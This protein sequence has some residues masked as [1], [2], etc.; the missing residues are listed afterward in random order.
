MATVSPSSPRS[1]VTVHCAS[2]EDHSARTTRWLK[3][4]F[5][6]I[7]FSRAVSL[8]YSRIDGPSA[9]AFASSQ[10]LKR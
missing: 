3:R 5:E 4:I 10:G 6:S 8:T 7:P 1:A 9:I 2:S